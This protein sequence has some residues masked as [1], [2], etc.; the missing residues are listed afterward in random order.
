MEKCT[1]Q[2]KLVNKGKTSLILSLSDELYVMIL[3]NVKNYL[4]NKPK[5]YKIKLAKQLYLLKDCDV[6]II[7]IYIYIFGQTS[8]SLSNCILCH[9]NLQK[10]SM[11]SNLSMIIRM[12]YKI[13]SLLMLLHSNCNFG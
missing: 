4:R 3:I 6:A 11:M 10:L 13:S 12:T 9:Y 1:R 7:D 8:S 2:V 5:L